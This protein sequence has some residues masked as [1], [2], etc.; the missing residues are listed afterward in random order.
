MAMTFPQPFGKYVLLQKIAMGG[1][2]EIFKAR[3]DGIGG[4]HRTFA[5]K[6]ILPSLA[7]KT[8]FVEMLV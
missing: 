1:M 8:E 2:A 6:R 7:S 3:M 4:F 5:I